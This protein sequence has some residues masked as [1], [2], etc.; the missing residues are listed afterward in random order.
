MRRLP[1]RHLKRPDPALG[2]QMIFQTPR[3][4]VQMHQSDCRLFRGQ[5]PL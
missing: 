3:V 2:R 4:L 5:L 1:V